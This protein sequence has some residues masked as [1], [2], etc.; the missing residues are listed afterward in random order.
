M[1]QV[2]D[3]VYVLGSRAHN[4][5][6]IVEDEEVTVIDAGCAGEWPKLEDAL[7]SVGIAR[8]QIAGFMITH[9]HSDHFGL[10]K[11]ATEEHLRVA[12]HVDDEARAVGPYKGRFSAET[13]D[14]PLYNPRVVWR[15]LP[16]MLAG[17]MRL[18]R[19]DEVE[20]FHD[21]E[22]LDVPGR[23]VAVHTPGHTEGHTMFH[24]PGLGTLFTGDGLV[25]MSL[26]GSGTGPR[27]MDEVFDLDSKQAHESLDRIVGLEAD[28]LL[29]GHGAPW[30]GSPG[31][32]VALAR[33]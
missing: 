12:V 14:L 15:F 17:V 30:S 6:L 8:E 21:G 23:P 19:V 22:T 2:A 16:L 18:E 7:G 28:L 10:A 26:L 29:P 13:S 9:V 4:Y 31:D 25:T 1:R 33:N 32:A 24:C 20:T 3:K 5:Y 27:F 11:K